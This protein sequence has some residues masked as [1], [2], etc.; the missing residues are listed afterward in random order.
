MTSAVIAWCLK[1]RFLILIIYL[2]TTLLG[3]WAMFRTPIDAIPDLSENQVIVF[4]EWTGR[5]AQ[6]VEDQVTYPLSTALQGLAGVKTVR[7]QSAFGFSM[8]TVIFEDRIDVYFA[9][10]R[11]LERLNSLPFKLPEGITPSLGPDATGLGWIYQYYLDDTSARQNGQ[12]LDLGELRAVQD[13]LV[14][15]Q[16][17]SVPGVAEV[18]SLGGYVRQYQVDVDPAKLRAYKITLNQVSQAV[19]GG[20]RNVGGGVIEQGGREFTLRGLALVHSLE[21]LRSLAVGYA[22]NQPIRLQDVATVSLG[23]ENRRGVL[24]KDGRE[25]VGGVVVMRY[26][27]STTDVLR[28]VKSKVQEIQSALPPGVEIKPFYDRSGL[29]DRAIHTLQIT[30]TEEI[31]LVTLAHIIFLF[32]FRSILIVTVPLP[33]SILISFILMKQFGITSNIMSLSGIAIAIGVLVD[34]GIVMTEAVMREARHAQEGKIPGLRYP[35][36]LTQ[37]VQRAAALVARPI[38]FSMAIIILAFIPVFALTGQEGKLFHPLAFTKTFAMAASTL[39]AMTLVPV[40]CSFFVRGAIHDEND[41]V[42][43][44]FLLGL[45]LPVLKWALNHRAAVL[46]TALALLAGAIFLAT[47]LGREFMPP[48]NERA[49]LFMP[50]TLPSASVPEIKRVMAAQDKILASFPEVESAVGKL[51]RAETATDPAP[52][53]MLETTITLKPTEEWREGTTLESLKAEMLREMQKFPGFVPAFLQPIENR[54]LMLSTGIRTQIGVK[55]F[56]DNLETLERIAREVEKA[57]QN[58]PGVADLYAERVTGAPYLEIAV[59]REDAAR[60]GVAISEITEVIETAL[61]GKV[62]S[63]TIEGRRRFPIRVRYARELRDSPEALRNALVPSMTG[64]P[65]PLAKVTDIRVTSGPAMISS[66]NGLLRVYVQANVLDRDLGGFVEEAKKIVA[67]DVKLPPGY[68]L[69]WSGQYENQIRAK[70][71]LQLVFPLVIL[72]IFVLLYLTYNSFSEAAHVLLAV[73]FALT[74]GIFLQWLLGYNFSV[75]V[76]V[77]YIALFGTAVQTGVVMVVYLEE[78]VKRKREEKGDDFSTADLAEAVVEG[79]ALRLR[80]KV[81]TVATV[82]ASLLVVMLPIFSGERTGVEIMRPI[83]VPVI[84]GMVSSLLHI[85]IVT[86]VIFLALRE[87]ELRKKRRSL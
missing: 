3:I 78:A 79:A 42:V 18:A 58:I 5:S 4:T 30:L 21:D 76:W 44:K 22:N 53:S 57:M 64:E 66:E 81:M 47:Q 68:Y 45:Y 55:I 80:P 38:F 77:G 9:R 37:I 86:P 83:A 40:L 85:L 51:G 56:G 50:T 74:G 1:N 31:I 8:L 36:D 52:T 6:E 13:W 15:Y 23:P 27:E 19:A 2:A 25:V 59:R 32:H 69:S 12:A 20:N 11:V 14:R 16:L 63:T 35:E 54:V 62:L 33:L 49:L 46:G 34:A 10:A 41:N 72:I 17:N 70:R 43:M 29:I 7:A 65:V 73:P 87:H 82:V 60:Y 71:T 84:G 26:G 39:L 61:G 24:D 28:R 48:L 75:A 67:R